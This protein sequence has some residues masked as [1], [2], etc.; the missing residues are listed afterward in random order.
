MVGQIINETVTLYGSESSKLCNG[1]YLASEL[2][3]RHLST[4]AGDFDIG[5]TGE[6][7]PDVTLSYYDLQSHEFVVSM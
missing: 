5:P 7:V 2:L 1:S 4:A 3:N 6:K